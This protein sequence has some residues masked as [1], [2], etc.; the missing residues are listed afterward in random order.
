MFQPKGVFTALVTPM[1]S[2]ESINFEE[3]RRQVDRQF[4]AGVHG[5]FCLGTNSE[6]YALHDDEKVDVAKTVVDQNSGRLP[7]IANVGC[8]TTRDTIN[9]AKSVSASGVDALSVIVPYFVGLSQDQLYRHYKS[10]AEAV[11]IP[12]FIYNIPMRTGNN[13]EPETVQRLSKIENIIGIKDSSGKIE[14]I[15]RLIEITDDNFSVLVGSDS[16]IL[17]TLVAGGLG[18]VAGCANPFP[19]LMAGIYDAWKAGDMETAT[20]R[21]EKIALFRSTFKLGNP[22]S[23]VKRAMVLMGQAVGPLR[24]PAHLLDPEIDKAIKAVL[25]EY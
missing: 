16:L 21:Q 4:N 19:E 13:I 7:L 20:R 11:D 8:V 15:K 2:D 24:E 10:V 14:N 3:L 18:A 23:I 5:L 12:V 9:L 25:V 22:N 17:Q 6:F 1:N